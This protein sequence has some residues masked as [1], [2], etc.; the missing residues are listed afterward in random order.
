MEAQSMPDTMLAAVLDG[1]REL[2]FERRP[3]PSPAPDQVLV[4]MRSV[5]VCGSDV[6]Y[7]DTGRIGAIQ[8]A[9]PLVLGHECAGIVVAVGSA[10]TRL[11]VG[12][13][14]ALEPG[15]PCRRCR[16]CLSGRYNLCPNVFFM[17]TPPDDG[18]FAEY[19][20][21]PADFTFGLPEH[22]SLDEGALLEP[23]SVGMHAARRGGIGPGSRV[24]VT[25]AGTI[26]LTALLAARAAGAAQVIVSDVIPSRLSHATELGATSVVNSRNASVPDVVRS[27]TDGEGADVVIEC[28]GA[29]PAESDA[30][31]SAHRG[32]VVVIV[33]L[34]RDTLEI[35]LSRLIGHELDIRGVHR[36][37]NTYAAAVRLVASGQINVKQLVTHHFSLPDVKEAME[38]AH[39]DLE[40]AIKVMVHPSTSVV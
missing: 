26:G 24:L 39:S 28:S 10:V 16:T 3:V 18:A 35:P 33:G 30:V 11:A 23:L 7:W 37:T 15:V 12:D 25:G 40:N 9:R 32:A 4:A 36:Y 31:M 34:G 21:H 27:L 6:H 5:G 13:R 1:R 2:R 22:V 19:V 29:G 14:V 38:T 17:A 8:I 20:A